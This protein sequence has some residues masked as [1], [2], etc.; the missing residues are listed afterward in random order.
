MEPIGRKRWAIAEGYIPGWSHGREPEM[1]SHE[2]AC[3][4]NASDQDAR[5]VITIFFTDRDA[6]GPYRVTVPARRTVHLR[7]DE[8][9]DPEPIPPATPYA[10]VLESDVPVVVQHTRLDSRQAENALITTIAFA[11]DS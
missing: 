3:I 8:L 10:S 9:D 4:L 2:T 1:T 11:G 7:F 6:A 5:V